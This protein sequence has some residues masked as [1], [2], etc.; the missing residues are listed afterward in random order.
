MGN[1]KLSKFDK[2]FGP[3]FP[4]DKEVPVVLILKRK[5]IR[6]YPDNQKVALYYSQALDK[7]VSIPFGPGSA[8]LGVHIN[9]GKITKRDQETIDSLKAKGLHNIAAEYEKHKVEGDVNK[10]LKRIAQAKPLKDIL[11]LPKD[12][13]DALW[14]HIKDRV[15]NADISPM[16]KAGAMTGL[17]LKKHFTKTKS[18]PPPAPKPSTVPESFRN[19]LRILREEK[20]DEIAPGILVGGAL[21]GLGSYA[22]KKGGEY[23][24]KRQAKKQAKKSVLGGNKKAFQ[25]GVK[26]RG[27]WKRKLGGVAA[28]AEIVA[29]IMSGAGDAAQAATDTSAVMGQKQGHEFGLKPQ[30]GGPGERGSQEYTRNNIAFTNPKLAARMGLMEN[31]LEVIKHIVENNI[32]FHELQ[33]GDRTVPLNNSVAKKVLKIYES[34]NKTNKKKIEKMLNEDVSSFRKV[35][36]FAIRQ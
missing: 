9:E 2:R 25:K 22:I 1:D 4:S 31:N 7:Y 14:P 18:T 34:V 8:S 28:G 23:L 19:N 11:S 26:K 36:N 30:V 33:F 21:R 27:G 24:A 35:I 32:K 16:S 13:R 6:V 15:R 12:E 10:T 20:L 17:I 29:G 3:D 5:A